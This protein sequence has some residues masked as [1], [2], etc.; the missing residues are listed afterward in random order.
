MLMQRRSFSHRSGS[1]QHAADVPCA[2]CGPAVALCRL[3]I[4][5]LAS[6]WP[7][8][9]PAMAQQECLESI[10]KWLQCGARCEHVLM[11]AEQTF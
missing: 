1:L 4:L 10:W 9:R 3:L 7:G 11:E 8:D 6:A 2:D 5:G